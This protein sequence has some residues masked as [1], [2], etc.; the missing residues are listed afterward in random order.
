MPTLNEPVRTVRWEMDAGHFFRARRS[1]QLA[2]TAV[3]TAYLILF[4]FMFSSKAA[5][6]F[7]LILFYIFLCWRRL[8]QDPRARDQNP[9]ET[10]R[11]DGRG[12]EVGH[13]RSGVRRSYVWSELKGYAVDPDLEEDPSG[14]VLAALVRKMTVDRIFLFSRAEKIIVL[15]IDREDKA[16]VVAEIKK[17]LPRRR[18]GKTRESVST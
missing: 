7:V 1:R 13:L 2:R 11:I 10:Y 9:V 5:F 14:R 12:I 3:V 4:A 6:L 8:S 18:D 17:R 15:C 16:E